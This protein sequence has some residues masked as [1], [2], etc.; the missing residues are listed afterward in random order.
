[1]CLVLA[2]LPASIVPAQTPPEAK[3]VPKEFPESDNTL[4]T[5][6]LKAGTAIQ[7]RTTAPLSSATAKVGD[8]LELRVSEAVVLDGQ[9][10]IARNARAAGHV[11][12]AREH[13]RL[14]RP[15]REGV[16]QQPQAFTLTTLTAVLLVK[17]LRQQYS[18]T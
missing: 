8:L 13:R 17:K 3:V 5:L 1:V 14:S 11:S 12:E 16:F 4:N 15:G 6:V 18:K 7:L 2:L 9:V 10:V